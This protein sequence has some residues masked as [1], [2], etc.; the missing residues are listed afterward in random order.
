MAIP[1]AYGAVAAAFGVGTGVMNWLN[2]KNKQ[3]TL[4]PEE[5]KARALA[6]QQSTFG[7]GGETLQTAAN[8]MRVQS[9]NVSQQVRANSYAAGLENSG[10]TNAAQQRVESLSQDKLATLALKIADRNAQ[11]RERA[12]ARKE[13]IN[14]QIGQRERQFEENR[15]EQMRQAAVQIGSSLLDF[16]AKSAEAKA[17]LAATDE[18]AKES[19]VVSDS[20]NEIQNALQ[21]EEFGKVDTL[22]EQLGDAEIDSIDVVKLISALMKQVETKKGG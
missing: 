5:R 20:I 17:S 13:A 8:Q 1:A 18:I 15:K 3:F 2:A 7:M 22:L 21:N 6:T 11:F 14:M 16:G 9:A 10:V 19:K 12:S 4:T